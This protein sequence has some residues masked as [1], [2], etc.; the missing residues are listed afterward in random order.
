MDRKMNLNGDNFTDLLKYVKSD[1]RICPQPKYW[2]EMWEMLPDKKRKGNS[3]DPPLPL[4][5]GAW[6]HTS[7]MEKMMRLRQHIEY[8]SEKGALDEI[9]DYLR[10]LAPDQWHKDDGNL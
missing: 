9:D 6:W 7:D 4:I 5:L 8:A 2:D 1:G 3:W 10:N